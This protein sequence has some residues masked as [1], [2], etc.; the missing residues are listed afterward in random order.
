[1]L[2]VLAMFLASCAGGPSRTEV[3]DDLAEEA[4][5]PAYQRFHEAA[6]RMESTIGDFCAAPDPAGVD[7]FPDRSR[8]REAG[9]DGYTGDVG[10]A[11]DGPAVLVPGQVAG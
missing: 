8:C 5:I 4:I 11:G 1:M 6:A 3:L 7:L 9:M 10:W 2:A